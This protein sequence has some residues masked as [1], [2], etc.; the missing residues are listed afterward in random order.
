MNKLSIKKIVSASLLLIAVVVGA[1]MIGVGL[2]GGAKFSF[3]PK[4]WESFSGFFNNMLSPILAALA[5]AIA[6]YSLTIQIRESRQEASLNEQISN[7]LKNIEM[8]QRMIEKRWK[9]I[10]KVSDK[11]WEDEPYAEI[12]EGSIKEHREDIYNLAPDIVRLC[13]LFQDLANAIQWY[14]HLHRQKI[15]GSEKD[16]PR[17]EWSHFS[18]SILQ[19]QDKKMKFC[20]E[21]SQ[22]FSQ[23]Q[24]IVEPTYVKELLIYRDFYANLV[25]TGTLSEA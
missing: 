2:I 15:S 18:N 16:F 14:T 12:S 21:V 8:L 25:G 9:T 7:Y 3:G 13:Q 23:R 22:W 19:E 4:A 6:F 24:D 11:N 20:Y 10:S 5:A 1:Y 17:K